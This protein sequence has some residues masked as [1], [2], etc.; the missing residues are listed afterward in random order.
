M[1]HLDGLYNAA[2]RRLINRMLNLAADGDKAKIVRAFKLAE[3][4]TP[5]SHKGSVRF[6]RDKVEAEHPVFL[7]ARHVSTKLSPAVRERFI[8]CLVVNS[9]LRGLAKRREL[10]ARTGMWAPTTILM[11]PTM[12]CNLACTGCYAGDYSPD[13]DLERE[14]LQRIVDEGNDMGVYLFT[15]LGGEP[16]LYPDLLGFA[17]ANRDSMFQVFTNGTLVTDDVIAELAEIGNIALIL[18][19]EGTQEQT[20]ERR[21]AGVYER[22]IK[23]MDRLGEAGVLFGYSSM[24]TSSNWDVLVSDEFVDPLIAKGA[25]IAWHFLYM[26]IGREPDVG[27][28]PTPAQREEFRKGILRLRATKPFFPVDFW[29]DAPWVGGCIA[30]KHYV[31]IT[32][33]GWVEPC[34]FT[35]FATDNIRDM[36]LLEAFN[37]PFFQEI[38][39]RQ[40]FND[41]LLMPCM[42]IDNPTCSREIMA[43]TGA[44]PTH[45]GADS[46]LVD[47]QKEIDDYA[48]EV[49]RV[50]NPAWRSRQAAK[51][52]EAGPAGDQSHAGRVEEG[53]DLELEPD[54]L[55]R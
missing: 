50:L 34:I 8:E 14:L 15:I 44:R 43:C 24:V 41:N 2:Q 11:S 13:Q 23:V 22:V 19:I 51:T 53:A 52:A 39:S 18:S 6:L 35:H 45:D 21:G 49:A 54:R 7:M 40:P 55:G 33:E 17:R 1:S 4:I 20:N 26:P 37:S 27:L 30:A 46:M 47:L 25:M 9:L 12:R 38:R 32:S 28:M 10:T 36:S 16:F 5:D 48:A 3:R 29:G 31:H 42:W